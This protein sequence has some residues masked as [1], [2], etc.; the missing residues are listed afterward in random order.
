MAGRNSLTGVRMRGL[1]TLLLSG[2][3]VVS[4]AAARADS[5]RPHDPEVIIGGGKGSLPVG[6]IFSFI[7]PSGTSP[8]TLSGGSPC[9]V[10]GIISLPDCIFKNATNSTW[11]GLS[12]T[13]TPDGQI[14]PFVCITL[15]DFSRCSFN[16]AGTEVTFSGGPGIGA[17][18]DFL[19]EVVLWLPG[20]Q[21]S[22]QAQDPPPSS[23]PE[24]A[25]VGLL[26]I[27][28]ATLLARRTLW[29]PRSSGV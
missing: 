5:I 18:D 12:F 13:I 21:F 1:S 4:C 15:D 2:M 19:V 6:S 9:L 16:S 26:L 29:P 8:I 10:G 23:T 20:T 14:G 11:T 28:F 7:S 24:P 25:T 27:G 17:G 3:I 22:G